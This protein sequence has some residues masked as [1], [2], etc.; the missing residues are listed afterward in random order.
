METIQQFTKG[1]VKPEKVSTPIHTIVPS[2]PIQQR[3]NEEPVVF[4]NKLLVPDFEPENCNEEEMRKF[5]KALED[6]KRVSAQ[7][8]QKNVYKYYREL[9]I[10]SREMSNMESEVLSFQEML[11]DLDVIGNSMYNEELEA[12][13]LSESEKKAARVISRKSVRLVHHDQ[14]DLYASQMTKLWSTIEGSQMMV[15]F[16]PNRHVIGSIKKVQEL[17]PLTLLVRQYVQIVVLNDSLLIALIRSQGVYNQA[18]L[19][20][21][22]C[23]R[24]NEIT[25]LQLEDTSGK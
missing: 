15:P 21:E 19:V 25:V 1:G 13:G 18:S 17:S 14:Q 6:S 9:L 11:A 20:A 3:G 2:K 10:V 8:L 23:M 5:R 22:R 16:S 7:S 24:L 4:L 12:S